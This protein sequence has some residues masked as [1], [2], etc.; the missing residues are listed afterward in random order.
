MTVS[1][2]IPYCA[3]PCCHAAHCE[4]W[5]GRPSLDKIRKSGNVRYMQMNN[6]ISSQNQ[7]F[8]A[9][10]SET[11]RI[12]LEHHP[13]VERE[14]SS[15]PLF[16]N[17]VSLAINTPYAVSLD[18]EGDRPGK[19]P[20]PADHCTIKIG[21]FQNQRGKLAAPLE[22]HTFIPVDDGR[23]GVSW[24]EGDGQSFTPQQLSEFAFDRLCKRLNRNLLSQTS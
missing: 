20:I 5:L 13:R 18:L 3:F 11:A 21:V 15:Y 2:F 6:I 22:D 14:L 19:N 7:F 1:D 4:I 23:G 10:E 16:F 8:D 24:R 17:Q 9:V 12:S